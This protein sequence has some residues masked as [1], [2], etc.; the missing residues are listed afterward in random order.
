MCP[1]QLLPCDDNKL[2]LPKH[3]QNTIY[4]NQAPFNPPLPV[5]PLTFSAILLRPQLSEPPIQRH[6]QAQRAAAGKEDPD[7]VFRGLADGGLLVLGG[8]AP[9]L[10]G[11]AG[12]DGRDGVPRVRGRERRGR[13]VGGSGGQ[14]GGLSGEDGEEV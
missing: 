11:E 6:G 7:L 12:A 2:Q 13:R 4:H 10:P 9:P 3:H 5:Q 1:V 14:E 8:R